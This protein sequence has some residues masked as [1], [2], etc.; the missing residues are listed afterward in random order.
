MISVQIAISHSLVRLAYRLTVNAMPAKEEWFVS[1]LMDSIDT[2]FDVYMF[3]SDGNIQLKDS[4]KQELGKRFNADWSWE[5]KVNE[6]LNVYNKY[7]FDEV[8]S[9]LKKLI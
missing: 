5:R 9:E 6:I 3:L 2:L 1:M 8:E 7:L 4:Q